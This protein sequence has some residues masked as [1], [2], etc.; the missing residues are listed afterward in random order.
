MVVT[1]LENRCAL[2]FRRWS[3]ATRAA[4]PAVLS[5]HARPND[6]GVLRCSRYSTAVNARC[7][8][9]GIDPA[10]THRFAPTSASFAFCSSHHPMSSIVDRIKNV[11]VGDQKPEMADSKDEVFIGSIDQ[12]TTSSRFLIFDRQGEPVAVHQE[13]FSQIYPNPG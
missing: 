3:S 2:F 11:V 5:S 10:Y 13:E 9:V 8:A 12:G 7:R 1:W 6:L 4:R